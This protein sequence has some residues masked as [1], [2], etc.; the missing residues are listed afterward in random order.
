MAH[1]AASPIDDLFG[2]LGEAMEEAPSDVL[3]EVCIY[4]R[5][6]LALAKD[7]AILKGALFNVAPDTNAL[8]QR[9]ANEVHRYVLR[10]ASHVTAMEAIKDGFGLM[11]SAPMTPGLI[12]ITFAAI[13]CRNIRMQRRLLG[14]GTAHWA[15]AEA[16]AEATA[17]ST[18]SRRRL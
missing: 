13:V 14:L 17:M 11:T 3:A 18:I 8:C 16:E 6:L 9:M 12:K 2:A 7:H 5:T 15:P 1:E 10:G 4:S